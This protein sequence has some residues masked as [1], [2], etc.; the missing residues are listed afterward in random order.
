MHLTASA[1]QAV[2]DTVD[3]PAQTT[4][5]RKQNRVIQYE[6]QTWSEAD[7][8]VAMNSEEMVDFLEL[9]RDRYELSLQQN[10]V[11]NLFGDP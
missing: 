1:V 2:P 11:V 6:A 3:Q 7:R 4:F 5:F 8:E 9:T 10:E